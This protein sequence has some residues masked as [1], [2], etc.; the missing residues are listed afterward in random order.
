MGV[1]KKCVK[2]TSR[3]FA[4]DARRSRAAS[5][6]ENRQQARSCHAEE[7]G[8]NHPHDL[9]CLMAQSIEASMLPIIHQ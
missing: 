4:I 6:D 2:A 5:T 1:A 8:K 7:Q 3:R 9:S